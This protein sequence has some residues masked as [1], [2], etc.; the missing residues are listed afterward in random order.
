[1]RVAV[2]VCRTPITPM[3]APASHCDEKFFDRTRLVT[4]KQAGTNS[5]VRRRQ[6]Q[7]TSKSSRLLWRPTRCPSGYRPPGSMASTNSSLPQK[8][9][10]RKAGERGPHPRRATGRRLCWLCLLLGFRLYLTVKYQ[11]TR[12]DRR[13]ALV[14]GK[15]LGF[16]VWRWWR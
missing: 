2:R 15:G 14:P 11:P 9:N 7:K 4:S 10:G 6:A 3:N 8:Q 13:Q 5:S 1:M 12:M 16:R